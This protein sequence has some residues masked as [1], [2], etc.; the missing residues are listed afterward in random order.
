MRCTRAT[1]VDARPARSR[2][3][4]FDIDAVEKCLEGGIIDL[5]VTYA[6]VLCVR[7]T[8]D[9]TVQTFVELA[10]SGAIEEQDFQCVAATAE[11]TRRIEMDGPAARRG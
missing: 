1:S 11:Q 6:F 9:T 7:N 3:A 2:R 10:H 8:E 5:N 4:R